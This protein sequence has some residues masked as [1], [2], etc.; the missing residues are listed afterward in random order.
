MVKRTLGDSGA[1][2]AS[3]AYVFLHYA[4]LVAYIS[5]AGTS[6]A[7]T[8]GQPLWA[9][10]ALF[11]TLLG[12]LC[13]GSSPR[14]LDAVNTGLLALVIASFVGLVAV[15]LPGVHIENLEVGSWPSVIDTLPVVALSFVYQNVVPV[16][17]TS[18]EGDVSKVRLAVWTGLAIPLVMFV[19]WEAALLGS[20]EPGAML[21]LCALA[22]AHLPRAKR[23]QACRQR[24]TKAGCA[25]GSVGG[26]PVM[27]LRDQNAVV[28]PLIEGFS[29]LAIATS[30]V[31]FVLGLS[32]LFLDALSLPNSNR[33]PAYALTLIPPYFFALAFPDVFFQALD[34]VRPAATSGCHACPL[35]CTGQ[36]MAKQFHP[37]PILHPSITVV[38][39]NCSSSTCTFA[40]HMLRNSQ[41]HTQ[42]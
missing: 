33:L 10:A 32:D 16:V 38:A 1:A 12:G 17:V 6:I 39:G 3:A 34:L 9:S 7:N 35:N 30:F 40:S 11:A 37:S 5:R 28:A 26:D 20:V 41:T 27:M 24:E 29:F 19:G 31:G 18:L 21:D 8:S 25:A 36:A 23:E 22:C 15:A 4:L 13:Y 2:V 42:P 14:L